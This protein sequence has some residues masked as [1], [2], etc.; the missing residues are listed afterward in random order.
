MPLIGIPMPGAAQEISLSQGPGW[1]GDFR[2]AGRLAPGRGVGG[3]YTAPSGVVRHIQG[4]APRYNI[5]IRAD[6]LI[7]IGP[8]SSR[9]VS[10]IYKEVHEIV[11]DTTRWIRD[12]KLNLTSTQWRPRGGSQYIR[13]SG[14]VLAPTDLR[15]IPVLHRTPPQ[16]RRKRLRIEHLY[17]TVRF[18]ARD[19]NAGRSVSALARVTPEGFQR[20][21][22]RGR[23]KYVYDLKIMI[24]AGKGSLG[25]KYAGI[26]EY[27]GIAGRGAQIPARPYMRPA[28]ARA[29][30]L[31]SQV[32]PRAAREVFV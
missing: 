6:G 18:S 21:V 32:L 3:F 10:N 28:A 14:P 19:P 27:G 5:T 9:L 4:I 26:H 15:D 25:L 31:I 13:S 16:G 17:S 1:V 29:Q 11:K 22:F 20:F 24:G 23:D 8:G 12:V 2:T 7:K 30:R